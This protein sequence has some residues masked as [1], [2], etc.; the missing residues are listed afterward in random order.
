MCLRR[1]Q[2]KTRW[3]EVK[4]QPHTLGKLQLKET[5]IFKSCR[6]NWIVE[7]CR[8]ITKSVLSRKSKTLPDDG[9]YVL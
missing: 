7:N 1:E 3:D 8:F 9:S 2:W 6:E 5:N 4:K